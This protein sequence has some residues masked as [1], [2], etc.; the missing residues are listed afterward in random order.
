MALRL[1]S[2]QHF[3]HY[4]NPDYSWL[5]HNILKQDYLPTWN[6]ICAIMGSTALSLRKRAKPKEKLISCF[7]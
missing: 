5:A 1:D 4:N 2:Q 7:N 6:H 3:W